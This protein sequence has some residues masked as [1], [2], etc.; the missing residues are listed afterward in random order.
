MLKNNTHPSNTLI[1]AMLNALLVTFYTEQHFHLSALQEMRKMLSED[2]LFGD[3]QQWKHLLYY[4]EHAHYIFSSSSALLLCYL[5]IGSALYACFL[6]VES[7]FYIYMFCIPCSLVCECVPAKHTLK[8][9]L[10]PNT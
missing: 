8:N 7:Y 10:I 9:T 4:R 3:K 2:K 5:I 1:T 6:C